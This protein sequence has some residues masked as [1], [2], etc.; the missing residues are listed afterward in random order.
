MNARTTTLAV[1]PVGGRRLGGNAVGL[2][3]WCSVELAGPDGS[4]ITVT[5]VPAQHGLDGSDAVIGPVIGFLLAAPAAETV[6]VS[7]ENGSLDVVREIAQRAVP[8]GVAVLFVGAVQRGQ[9]CG[10]EYLTLSGD[11]AADA[12]KILGVRTV[13]PVHY[14]GWTHF[15][16]G[17]E[18][19]RGA[20]GGN[21]VSDR[22]VLAK[23]GARIE[24]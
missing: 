16:Q 11:H 23:P 17:A 18:R 19:L 12:A 20:F 15:T 5:A 3:P 1:Q 13:V 21:C 10:C 6:Y 8:V 4:A 14:E 22:L 2:Q 9:E 24:L 7:G